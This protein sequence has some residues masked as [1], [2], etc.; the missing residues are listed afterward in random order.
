M[1]H[2]PSGSSIP[3]SFRARILE[4]VAIPFSRGIFLTQRS[5]SCLLHWQTDSLTAEP[6]G[7]PMSLLGA[8]TENQ[9]WV[10][11]R[12]NLFLT[13]LEPGSSR[14]RCH[15]QGGFLVGTPLLEGRWQPSLRVCT[16][17]LLHVNKKSRES[18]SVSSSSSKDSMPVR[19]GP[20]LMM[21][22]NLN[23]SRKR[24]VSK[25][26]HSSDQSINV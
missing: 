3:G 17:P 26:S 22:L 19:L 24:S 1:D 7:L 15:H 21:S 4:W 25:Y 18:S 14:S 20:S 23:Y 12:T 10:A 9:D 2:S 8:I 6:P 16:W 11:Q 13:V 5:N